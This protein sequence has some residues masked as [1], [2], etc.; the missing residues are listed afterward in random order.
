[1]S[2]Q[3]MLREILY[4]RIVEAFDEFVSKHLP[5]SN[6]YVGITEDIND[7]LFNGHQLDEYDLHDCDNA[8]NDVTARAVEKYFLDKGMK[9]AGGGEKKSSKFVYIYLQA[10]HTKP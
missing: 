7:C 6:W 10:K 4:Q 2:L 5:Y 8:G 3:K 1:M 9:S